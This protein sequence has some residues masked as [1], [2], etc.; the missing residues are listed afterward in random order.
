MKITSREMNRIAS[1]IDRVVGDLDVRAADAELRRVVRREAEALAAE[2]VDA[3]TK[4]AQRLRDSLSRLVQL[5]D[6]Q[7]PASGVA[8]PKSLMSWQTLLKALAAVVGGA[9]FAMPAAAAPTVGN[10]FTHPSY[11]GVILTWS[12]VSGGD[13]YMA[14]APDGTQYAFAVTPSINDG[15]LLPDGSTSTVVGYYTADNTFTTSVTT[16]GTFL[17]DSVTNAIVTSAAYGS[18]DGLGA[19]VVAGQVSLSV[20][21]DGGYAPDIPDPTTTSPNQIQDIRKGS[22]GKNGN[23]GYF[24]VPAG[25][26]GAGGNGPAFTTNRI[27]SSDIS[28]VTSSPTTKGAPA[29]HIASI[30]G[31]GGDGGDSYANLAGGGRA[32][33]AGGSGGNINVTLGHTNDAQIFT[34]G[35]ATHGVV[36]QSIAGVGGEGGSQT[37]TTGGS[38]SGGVAA[39]GGRVIADVNLD[40]TTVGN[41]SHGVLIQSLGGGA[42]KS[43]SSYG[44]F[45]YATNGGWGGNGGNV[46]ATVG[47]N[48]ETRGNGS[49]GVVVQSI[50]GQGGDG[51]GAGGIA[52]FGGDGGVGGNGGTANLTFTGNVT[53]QGVGSYGLVVQSIGGSG[54]NGGSTGGLVAL[55]SKG[56]EGGNGGQ[57]IARTTAGSQV[58]TENA[59]SFGVLAQSIGGGGGNAGIS[60]GL[61][62]VGGNGQQGGNASTVTAI[63]GGTVITEGVGSSGV[64]AQSIGGGGGTGRASAGLVALGSSGAGGGTADDVIVSVERTGGIST[65]GIAAAGIL[66]QSIGGGGG[67]AGTTGG[68][69][70]LGSKGAGGGN[71]GDVTVDNDGTILTSGKGSAGSLAQAI[72]GGGG[73]GAS[74]DGCVALGS[75]GAGGGTGG[76]VEVTNSGSMDIRGERARGIVAQS[77]GGGGGV[78][79]IGGGVFASGGNGGSGGAAGGARIGGASTTVSDGAGVT[80]SNSGRIETHGNLGTAIM[81]QSIGGGGGDGA[82]SVGLTVGLGGTAGA[83]GAGGDVTVINSGKL[84]THGHDAMGVYAQSIGGGGGQGGW[85]AAIGVIAGVA[86]GGAGG[87]GGDGGKV[88]L[89]FADELTDDTLIYTQ[90]DRSTGV[91]AQSIGGGGGNGGFAVAETLGV[92]A[93]VSIGIGGQGGEGGDGGLVTGSGFTHIVTEG[94]FADGMLLQSVGGGG[95]NGGFSIT[96]NQTVGV[97]SVN[98]GIGG[99]GG[100]GGLGGTVEFR[101]GGGSISNSGDFSKGLVAQSVCGVGGIGGDVSISS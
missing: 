34:N 73:A 83:G 63:I 56:A 62:S 77:I 32:G 82:N 38:G 16:D 57:V 50:G 44:L 18:F 79:G 59:L 69:V 13:S 68:L 14:V 67:N 94:D 19:P 42:G 23:N 65:S 78:G 17:Y 92:V 41:D 81:A 91:F 3:R 15:V 26:G 46:I 39:N 95:G 66:A 86:L 80:V 48:I 24:F 25:K 29:I 9:A 35:Y 90:G 89:A 1:V 51:G 10:T 74:A 96:A 100:D 52:A 30:G 60:A 47:G 99:T 75:Q 28:V 55:G 61:V 76:D 84:I 5:M 72:G 27:V 64:V 87:N 53:T 58:H 101:N 7:E 12:D 8:R 31:N 11:P 36:I 85:S 93:G 88:E 45:G 70:S 2:L 71:A 43:G 33:G 98:V 37:A 97:A 49:H 21:T 4:S 54:G 20:S 6:T 22:K 40:I